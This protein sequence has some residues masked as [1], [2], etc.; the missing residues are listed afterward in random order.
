MIRI[1]AVNEPMP[2]DVIP[3][4]DDPIAPLPPNA[5]MGEEM[6]VAPAGEPL[7]VGRKIEPMPDKKPQADPSEMFEEVI[8]KDEPPA[9]KEEQLSVREKIH[10]SLNFMLPLRILY[11]SLAGLTTERTVHPDYVYWAGTR[12]H[13]LVAW[14]EMK[15]DWRAFVVD[16]IRDAKLEGATT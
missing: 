7:P 1:Y 9:V 13:I 14:D 16:R 8:Y 15:N 12:R 10:R 11:T 3:A 4:D 5:P 2:G 6:E